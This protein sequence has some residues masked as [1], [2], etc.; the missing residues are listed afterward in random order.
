MDAKNPAQSVLE[1]MAKSIFFI[2][3]PMTLAKVRREPHRAGLMV[4]KVGVLCVGAMILALI[5]GGNVAVK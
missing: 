3:I 2:L 4:H 5:Q 1:K